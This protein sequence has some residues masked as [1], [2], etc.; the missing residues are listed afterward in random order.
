MNA[1]IITAICAVL[2]GL[3]GAILST[4]LA[5]RD[6]SK[7]KVSC[8]VGITIG[9]GIPKQENMLSWTVVNVSKQPVTVTHVGGMFENKE[10]KKIGFFLNR[11]DLPMKLNYGDRYT[12]TISGNDVNKDEL[13]ELSVYDTLNRKFK[14]SKKD[15]KSVVKNLK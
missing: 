3:Y 14:C 6:R 15:F 8:M 1:D 4:I 9:V 10:G 11:P 2:I 5:L 12:F 13:I 7:L